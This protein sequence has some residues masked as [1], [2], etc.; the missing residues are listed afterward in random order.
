MALPYFDSCVTFFGWNV[1]MMIVFAVSFWKEKWQFL[2]PNTRSLPPVNSGSV[3]HVD[4]V[5]LIDCKS[6]RAITTAIYFSRLMACMGFSSVVAIAPCKHW[7]WIPCNTFVAIKNRSHDRTVWTALNDQDP[8]FQNHM[9]HHVKHLP[10]TTPC[11]QPSSG[12]TFAIA[13]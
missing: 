11:A 13:I 8:L 3:R 10:W 1:M 7:H 12:V 2:V 4:S 9:T 6:E 5:T